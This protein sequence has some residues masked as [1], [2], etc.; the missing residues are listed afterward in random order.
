MDVLQ[1]HV[2][3]VPTRCEHVH[4]AAVSFSMDS[5]LNFEA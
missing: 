4:N 1:I 3:S 5:L 2:H